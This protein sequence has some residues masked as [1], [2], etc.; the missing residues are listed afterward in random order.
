MITYF[1]VQNYKTFYKKVEIDFRLNKKIKRFLVNGIEEGSERLLK[2]IGIYGPNN[3]GKTCLL[4]SISNLKHLMLGEKTESLTNSFVNDDIIEYQ[5][6]YIVKKTKYRYQLRYNS[7]ANKY[8]YERISVLTN[9]ESNAYVETETIILERHEQRKFFCIDWD[10]MKSKYM[11]SSISTSQ[12]LMRLIHFI[13]E[14]SKALK[15]KKDYFAF[16]DSLENV[17]RMDGPIDTKKTINLMQSDPKATEFIKEF[18][19]NCDLHIDDFGYQEN[20]VSDIDLSN[21]AFN[22]DNKENIK[23]VSKHKQYRVPSFVF[24]S[25]GTLKLIALSGYI[26]DAIVNGKILL[27]DEIDSSLH[28]IITRAIVGLFNNDLNKKAQLIFSTHDAQLLDLVRLM[29]KDQIYLVDYD[30]ET[31][32]SKVVHLTS[33]SSKEENGIRG[34]EEIRDY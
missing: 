12:P 2:S 26:Y 19:K 6:E 31:G 34:D 27:I 11:A 8:I 15:A 33:F 22:L 24:D 30:Q 16:L 9:P 29:R 13:N 1:S 18:I 10:E 32:F 4:L 25:I 23:F 17:V 28:H 21:L 20:V 5:V 7:R 3:A 14:D